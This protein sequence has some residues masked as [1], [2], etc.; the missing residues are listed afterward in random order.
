MPSTGPAGAAA[1]GPLASKTHSGNKGIVD[2]IRIRIRIRIRTR[3]SNNDKRRVD[4][5]SQRFIESS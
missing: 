3:K 4:N 2:R 1:A 5:N